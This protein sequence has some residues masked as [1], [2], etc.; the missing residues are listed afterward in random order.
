M[1]RIKTGKKSETAI[2]AAVYWKPP[3]CTAIYFSAHKLVKSIV[4]CLQLYLSF[5][6]FSL[7]LIEHLFFA[8]VFTTYFSVYFLLNIFTTWFRIA[9]YTE[10]NVCQI[11]VASN[12]IFKI[13]VNK[14]M[15]NFCLRKKGG[16]KLPRLSNCSILHFLLIWFIRFS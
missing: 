15:M 7:F 9:Q 1:S 5:V 14:S 11:Y 8:F 6:F 13:Q 2:T 4:C 10:S 3:R 12:I 16:F